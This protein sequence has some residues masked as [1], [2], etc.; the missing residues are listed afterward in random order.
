MRTRFPEEFQNMS[1]DEKSTFKPP[2]QAC[3]LVA[4]QRFVVRKNTGAEDILTMDKDCGKMWNDKPVSELQGQ[5]EQQKWDR[6]WGTR[7]CARSRNCG[8]G[9]AK[10]CSAE[11]RASVLN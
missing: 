6:Q 1:S 4:G 5:M 9:H 8:L 3:F 2:S 10:L 11:M 7:V